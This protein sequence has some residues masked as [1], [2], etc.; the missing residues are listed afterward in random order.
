[1]AKLTLEEI[2]A[3]IESAV[4]TGGSLTDMPVTGSY[5][6][7]S[8]NEG[9]LFLKPVAKG[10]RVNITDRG[11]AAILI[12]ADPSD[13]K[14]VESTQ[15]AREAGKV[16]NLQSALAQEGVKFT[17]DTVLTVAAKLKNK[18]AE[19]P[20]EW[21]YRPS[22]Y[23][24]HADYRIATTAARKIEDLDERNQAFADA[25][26]ALHKSGL[27]TPKPPVN[28]QTLRTTPVFMMTG[29]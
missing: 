17:A 4:I 21:V 28:E 20:G 10:Q 16:L 6:I 13:V 3:K 18:D 8:T 27:K 26:V 12:A 19:N 1:M 5:K 15:D 24:K 14:D 22:H 7:D 11:L 9:T 29:K 2:K 23:N 25:T